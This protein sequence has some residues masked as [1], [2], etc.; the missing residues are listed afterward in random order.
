MHDLMHASIFALH[1]LHTLTCLHTCLITLYIIY[2]ITDILKL[3]RTVCQNISYI[4]IC[5][6]N[7]KLTLYMRRIVRVCVCVCVCVCACACVCVCV[8][9]CVRVCVCVCVCIHI[10][11]IYTYIKTFINKH[12]RTHESMQCSNAVALCSLSSLFKSI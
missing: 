12:I 10:Q 4:Y 7:T 6:Y 8:C 1:V 11:S 5:L 3:H 9:V 2:Y